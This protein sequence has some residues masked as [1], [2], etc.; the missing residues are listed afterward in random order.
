MT[1]NSTATE[2]SKWTAEAGFNDILIPSLV[3]QLEEAKRR[4]AKYTALEKV[5]T[6]QLQAQKRMEELVIAY[7]SD[8]LRRHT[9]HVLLRHYARRATENTDKSGNPITEGETR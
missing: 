5:L 8:A 9:G 2:I 4:A 1:K 6:E 3:Q 7:H